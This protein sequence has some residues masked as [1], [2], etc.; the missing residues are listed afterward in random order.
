MSMVYTYI[1]RLISP[2][3]L[4]PSGAKEHLTKHWQF[5]VYLLLGNNY[6]VNICRLESKLHILSHSFRKF[7][8]YMRHIYLRMNFDNTTAVFVK[9]PHKSLK[10]KKH[11]SQNYSE[12]RATHIPGVNNSC[13]DHAVPS[14]TSNR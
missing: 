3:T 7:Q 5:L 2:I 4:G 12:F 8:F 14:E 13:A 9:R 1:G 6:R 11:I 10:T